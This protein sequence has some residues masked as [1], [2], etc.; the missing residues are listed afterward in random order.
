MQI[1]NWTK[2]SLYQ[3]T[4]WIKLDISIVLYHSTAYL[5]KSILQ[6]T[7]KCLYRPT[8][9]Y[10]AMKFTQIQRYLVILYAKDNWTI[11]VNIPQKKRHIQQNAV[12]MYVTECVYW[13]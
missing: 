6:V 7:I 9:S 8:A 3:E 11:P 2:C 4:Q 10:S 13:I 5:I 1:I 12:N